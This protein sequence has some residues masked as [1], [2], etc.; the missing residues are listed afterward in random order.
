MYIQRV[1]QLCDGG[2][3][4]SRKITWDFLELVVVEHTM[5]AAD[6]LNIITNQVHLFIVSVPFVTVV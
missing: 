1:I 4:L 2:V 6:Y 5:I 3:M